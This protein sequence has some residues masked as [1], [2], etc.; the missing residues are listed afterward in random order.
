MM[1]QILIN[2]RLI[3]EII[4]SLLKYE[5]TFVMKHIFCNTL[6]NLLAKETA[7]NQKAVKARHSESPRNNFVI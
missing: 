7:I 5:K 6:S 3:I 2:N 4:C 1:K